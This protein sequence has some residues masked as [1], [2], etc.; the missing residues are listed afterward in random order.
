MKKI[1][2]FLLIVFN[3]GC[4]SLSQIT[5]EVISHLPETAI[6]LKL[7]LNQGEVIRYNINSFSKNKIEFLGKTQSFDVNIDTDLNMLV[8]KINLDTISLSVAI[9]RINGTIS[10]N[11]GRFIIPGIDKI[12]GKSFDLVIKNNGD[13]INSGKISDANEFNEI[14]GEIVGMFLFIPA[15]EIK[16]KDIW[17]KKINLEKEKGNY[18]FTLQDIITERKI[19]IIEENGTIEIKTKK[20]VLGVNVEFNMSGNQKSEINFSIKKGIPVEKTTNISLSGEA[21][22]SPL[23]TPVKLFIDNIIKLKII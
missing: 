4:A 23:N 18:T 9:D 3:F 16:I 19:G 6:L 11:D 1:L 17:N 7:V 13:I 14:L 2:C 12:K 22:V 20:E 5:K 21:N 8:K 15:K 10:S